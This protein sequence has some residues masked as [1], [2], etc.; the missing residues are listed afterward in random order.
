MPKKD[1]AQVRRDLLARGYEVRLN[2]GSHYKV[3]KDR[4]PVTTF[5]CSPSSARWKAEVLA[6][7]RRFE[8]GRLPTDP[9]KLIGQQRRDDASGFRSV[10]VR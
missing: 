2:K 5:G 4:T 8:E 9:A 6:A 3:F 7:V 1:V 10:R